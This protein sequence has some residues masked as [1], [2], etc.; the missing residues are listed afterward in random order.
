MLNIW[1]VSAPLVVFECEHARKKI[2][3]IF[4][5]H[6]VLKD[7]VQLAPRNQHPSIEIAA[8]HLCLFTI[9]FLN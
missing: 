6:F 8:A 9:L 5:F 2:H 3:I 4:N 7:S 1:E